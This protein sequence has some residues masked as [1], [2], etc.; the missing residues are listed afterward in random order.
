MFVATTLSG[1]GAKLKL[2]ACTSVNQPIS[3]SSICACLLSSTM[4]QTTLAMLLSSVYVG[5]P[6]RSRH[7]DTSQ[8]SSNYTRTI[9]S[10][11]S[12]VTISTGQKSRDYKKLQGYRIPSVHK[13]RRNHYPKNPFAC[14]IKRLPTH[15][16]DSAVL[17]HLLA[18]LI[19]YGAAPM[20]GCT[21]ISPDTK[22][23]RLQQ[24]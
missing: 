24:R 8:C 17:G 15:R 4:T 14:T 16:S 9:Y 7:D 21:S 6:I 5:P 12:S 20:M 1:V 3:R 13:A 19:T 18:Q 10:R 23:A 22:T 11:A 2:I